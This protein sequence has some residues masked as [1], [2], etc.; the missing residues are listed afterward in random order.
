MNISNRTERRRGIVDH[1]LA[2]L[3]S[4]WVLGRCIAAVDESSEMVH[5]FVVVVY[6]CKNF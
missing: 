2:L 5:T 1:S 4:R 3:V 6:S